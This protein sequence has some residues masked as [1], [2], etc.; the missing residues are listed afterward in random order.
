MIDE[1]ERLRIKKQ[2]DTIIGRM[3]LDRMEKKF[4]KYKRIGRVL[5]GKFYKVPLR[6]ILTKGVKEIDLQKYPEWGG[7][8]H[9]N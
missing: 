4:G 5:T 9:E 3:L 7:D 6:D 8:K 2:W 1:M